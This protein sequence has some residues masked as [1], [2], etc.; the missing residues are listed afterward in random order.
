MSVTAVRFT[1][2]RQEAEAFADALMEFN[3]LSVS[4]EDAEA[5]TQNEQPIFG[6]PG[7]EPGFWALC[8]VAA[9]FPPDEDVAAALAACAEVLE[10]EVPAYSV[11]L[12]ADIDWVRANQAQFQPIAVSERLW[13]VPSW[14]ALDPLPAGALPIQID[15]GAAFGTGS[16]PTTRL[17]LR[18]LEAQLGR[19][20]TASVLDYGCGSGILAIAALKL[21]AG[22]A[23]GVDIDDQALITARHNADVNEVAAT[24]LSA[25]DPHPAAADLV[26]ANILSHPLIMLAPFLARCVQPGGAMALSGI[27]AHQADDVVAAYSRWISLSVAAQ[28]EDWVCLSGDR[29]A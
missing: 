13:I 19:R 25:S 6:E 10:L 18:W 14:H 24:F 27:L 20:P 3:C 7:A 16:H 11:E 12:L 15:P 8:D 23:V 17:C 5:G 26:V 1:L 9:H 21:G 22:A 2:A 28:D 4:V 29:P